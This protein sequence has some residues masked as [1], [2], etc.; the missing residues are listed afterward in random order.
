LS[1]QR[2]VIPFVKALRYPLVMGE[3][4]T[5]FNS[6][7]ENEDEDVDLIGLSQLADKFS[8]EEID[9]FQSNHDFLQ[10]YLDDVNPEDLTDQELDA[11]INL[12]KMWTHSVC[13]LFYT[14]PV[15]FFQKSHLEKI[16]DLPDCEEDSGRSDSC[17]GAHFFITLQSQVTN[18]ILESL[19]TREHYD[20]HFFPWLVARNE[21]ASPELL[22]KV[23]ETCANDFSW[24]VG[25]YYTNDDML[26]EDDDYV[27]SFVLFQ[28][29]SNPNTPQ[30]IK[31]R[32]ASKI[33]FLKS[34]QS[35]NKRSTLEAEEIQKN[36]VSI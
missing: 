23:A 21:K 36:L 29:A 33:N 6:I 12:A 17:Y 11:V 19:L 10:D 14:A 13:S 32:F 34:V 35:S 2:W 22:E 7:L 25:G 16:L 4:I 26:I 3:N 15:D 5:K 8:E 9:S 18:E 27:G 31:D 30:E 20:S 1:I 24:R 28:L